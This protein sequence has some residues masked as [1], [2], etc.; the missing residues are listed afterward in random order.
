MTRY[1]II[2][3]LILLF[4][5]QN[6]FSQSNIRYDSSEVEI[7]MPEENK[8]IKFQNDKDFIYEENPETPVSI[9]D[10]IKYWLWSLLLKFFSDTGVAPY[11]RYTIIG[12][13]ATF[14]IVKLFK[15]N[16]RAV[17][18][19][20]KK[21]IKIEHELL[22]EDLNKLNI[23]KLLDDSIKNKEF[24]KAVRY[25]FLKTLKILIA[26]ELINKRIDKTNN[27]FVLELKNSKYIKEFKELVSFYEYGW[28]G[29]FNISQEQ[30]LMIR[31]KYDLFL[32]KIDLS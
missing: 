10:K 14:F 20:P 11:I 22:D 7:K 5:S 9:L 25:L 28:Y 15:T 32:K 16:I 24:R 8:I 1:K 3:I 18:Y 2:L 4:F 29:N 27:E 12:I 13:V 26:T 21:R 23:D 19:N 31:E 17:F 6:L 30:F